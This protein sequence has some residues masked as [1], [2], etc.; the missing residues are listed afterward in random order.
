MDTLRILLVYQQS[1]W[2]CT[3]R[4]CII[5]SFTLNTFLLLPLNK[6]YCILMKRPQGQ[7]SST[8]SSVLTQPLLAL[9]PVSPFLIQKYE[10]IYIYS[11]YLLIGVWKE[12]RILLPIILQVET[13]HNRNWIHNRDWINK[14]ATVS[15]YTQC[16]C[17]KRVMGP[18]YAISAN[19]FVSLKLFQNQKLK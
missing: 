19:F 13:L 5:T 8:P 11:F 18:L 4:I 3:Q 7:E 16:Y 10:K 9:W 17:G 15:C 12:W 1:K 2:W 14:N 6:K